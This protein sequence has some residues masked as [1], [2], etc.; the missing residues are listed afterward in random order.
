[1]FLIEYNDNGCTEETQFLKDKTDKSFHEVFFNQLKTNTSMSSEEK[2]F[3]FDLIQGLITRDP[4]AHI[5]MESALEQLKNGP[6]TFC[7]DERNIMEDLNEPSENEKLPMS[8]EN[9]LPDRP[10]SMSITRCF[11]KNIQVSNSHKEPNEENKENSAPN[12]TT[13]HP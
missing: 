11:R 7:H 10:D 4:N 8:H 5:S 6:P 12:P 1:M 13:S 9:T 2:K 3:Y